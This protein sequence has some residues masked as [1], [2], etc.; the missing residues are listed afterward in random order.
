M[1]V[2]V[3]EQKFLLEQFEFCLHCDDP[4]DAS[5]RQSKFGGSGMI[6]RDMHAMHTTV[7]KLIKTIIFMSR[8]A[9]FN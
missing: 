3:F 4:H 9:V 5:Y 7:R 8:I 1:L 2:I 6:L